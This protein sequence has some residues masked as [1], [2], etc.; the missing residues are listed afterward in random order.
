MKEI[1]P[2]QKQKQKHNL[3]F[4]MQANPSVYAFLREAPT[5]PN[6]E[7]TQPHTYL[8]TVCDPILLFIL[9]LKLGGKN[10]HTHTHAHTL[11]AVTT[12]KDR[13]L[14]TTCRRTQSISK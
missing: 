1:T 8:Y 4:E 14:G 9:I 3:Y 10:T 5:K 11:Q 12:S 7:L 2:P 6:E 13:E